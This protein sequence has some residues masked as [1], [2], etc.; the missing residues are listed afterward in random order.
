MKLEEIFA[1]YKSSQ[2][3][4]GKKKRANSSFCSGCYRRLPPRM[5][6]RLYRLFG[7]GYESA[8]EQ[9]CEYLDAVND[10]NKVR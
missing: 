10:E 8:Y 1:Q 3:R 2:C 5:R 4:C 9:A 6:S 7:L